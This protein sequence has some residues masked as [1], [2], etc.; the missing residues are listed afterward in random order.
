M[1]KRSPFRYMKPGPG[2]LN[3]LAWA[4]GPGAKGREQWTTHRRPISG[5]TW[6]QSALVSFA[7]A[8]SVSVV[9]SLKRNFVGINAT[10]IHASISSWTVPLLSLSG[11]NYWSH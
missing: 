4:R 9:N 8:F 11:A 6:A 2:F 1:T 10:F 5:V 7:R 3:H